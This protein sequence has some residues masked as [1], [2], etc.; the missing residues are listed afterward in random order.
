MT[1]AR[2]LLERGAYI[3]GGVKPSEDRCTLTPLQLAAATGNTE[4][5]SLLLAHGANACLSTLHKVVTI[6]VILFTSVG[7]CL[8]SY[9]ICFLG[10]AV[11]FGRG[12]AWQP[13]RHSCGG[14]S[15][16]KG[17]V[18]QTL[19]AS[20][21]SA[22]ER[23]SIPGRDIGGGVDAGEAHSLPQDTDKSA[24]GGDVPQLGMWTPRHHPRPPTTRSHLDPSLLDD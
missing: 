15:R 24:A 1:L 14:C 12:A 3:E 23:S 5:V 11:L 20:T 16:T 6:V 18:A 8:E 10:L 7:R 13:L 21:F 2:L 19:V 4:M 22:H 9:G 17:Y